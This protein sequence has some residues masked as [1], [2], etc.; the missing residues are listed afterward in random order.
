[1]LL[2]VFLL[3]VFCESSE[4]H[5]PLQAVAMPDY[6]VA[7]GQTVQLHCS[8]FQILTFANWSWQ[9]LENRVWHQVG[10]ERDLIL[11]EPEQSGLYRCW[12]KTLNS[13]LVSH[14]LTVYIIDMPPTAGEKLGIAA[15]V[16]SLLALFI[17]LPILVW[18]VM[19][20][21]GGT[22]TSFKTPPKDIQ[23]LEKTS[24]GSFPSTER[25]GNVYMNYTSTNQAYT[26]LDPIKMTED[27]TYSSLS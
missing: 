5:S 25:D 20:R 2:C 24:K 7:A 16:L 26:N 22:F 9:H 4:M 23:G 17:T 14:N 27:N 12:A 18:F 8:A 15:V 11:T 10:S 3:F 19:Q 21:Y 6:P 13:E 1:M